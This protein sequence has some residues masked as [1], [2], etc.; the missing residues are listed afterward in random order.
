[1][2]KFCVSIFILIL[3]FYSGH[4]VYSQIATS[5]SATGQ[6]S[7]EIIPIFSASETAQMNFGKFSPGPGGG[8]LILTPLGTISALG[9]IFHREWYS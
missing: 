7:A 1:M 5:V 4:E 2:K 9:S 6:I 8:D 3:F